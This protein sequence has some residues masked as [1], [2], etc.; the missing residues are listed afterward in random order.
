MQKNALRG[1]ER[2]PMTLIAVR[3][4]AVSPVARVTT[5]RGSDPQSS[6]RRYKE[7]F[8]QK[9]FNGDSGREAACPEG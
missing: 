6:M 1:G 4:W 5:L 9:W 3:E 2:Y 7:E 8:T